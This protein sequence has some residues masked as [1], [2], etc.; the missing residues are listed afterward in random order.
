MAED[1]STDT[2]YISAD[3]GINICAEKVHYNCA[4]NLT[5]L[6]LQIARITLLSRIFNVQ[7]T[8]YVKIRTLHIP[9]VVRR[10]EMEKLT[11]LMGQYGTY[12]SG[13]ID[14]HQFVKSLSY[15]SAKSDM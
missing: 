10:T 2:D 13:D 9:V 8:A 4:E 6:F 11:N 5:K 14:C 3:S 12:Q 1:I 15:R 7:A